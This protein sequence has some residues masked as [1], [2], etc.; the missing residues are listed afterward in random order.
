MGN[1]TDRDIRLW[2]LIALTVIAT[3]VALPP[4][5]LILQ[6]APYTIG[7]SY[8]RGEGERTRLGA[9]PVSW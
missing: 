9:V 2:H 5:L 1:L 7:G 4:A 6:T 3:E 8:R